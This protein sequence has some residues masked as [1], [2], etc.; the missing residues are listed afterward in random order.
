MYQYV[1]IAQVVPRGLMQD[2]LE[3][4]LNFDEFD[5]LALFYTLPPFLFYFEASFLL[6]SLYELLAMFPVIWFF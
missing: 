3:P 1:G 4:S 6:F 2:S 5:D